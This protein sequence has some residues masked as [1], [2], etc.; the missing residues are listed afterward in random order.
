MLKRVVIKLSGEALAGSGGR[1]FDDNVIGEITAQIS[2]AVM[3]GTQ[4]SIVVGGGNFWRGRDA[5]PGM[6][7]VKADHIGMMATIMNALYL[8]EAFKEHGLESVVMT[9]F[10]VGVAVERFTKKSALQYMDQG[11]VVIFA[12]GTGH[13]FFSTDTIAAIRAAELEADAL[14]FAKNNVDGVYDCDP[15]LSGKARKLDKV[16]YREIIASNL[17]IID[18][19][20][21]AICE[22]CRVESIIFCLDEP[23][24]VETAVNGSE[25][26]IFK[27][28][29]KVTCE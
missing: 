2:R 28:G 5:R 14:L 20:A 22:S 13:P 15:R 6:D 18:T 9:P 23:D 7:K 26:E 19:A 1:R 17:G 11:A 21:S 24:G 8:T 3:G 29:T 27:I 12:G 25:A 16:T 10:E 4:V